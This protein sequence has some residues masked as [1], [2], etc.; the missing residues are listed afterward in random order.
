MG[1]FELVKDSIQQARNEIKL[2]REQ[3]KLL[4]KELVTAERLLAKAKLQAA[5]DQVK[6]DKKGKSYKNM[7]DKARTKQKFNEQRVLD[8][9]KQ[10]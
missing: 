6:K 4:A 2:E 10:A 3:A 8:F 9:E 5:K 1:N 7:Y